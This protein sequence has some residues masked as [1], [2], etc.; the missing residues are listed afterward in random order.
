MPSPCALPCALPCLHAWMLTASEGQP[1]IPNQVTLSGTGGERKLSLELIL[2]IMGHILT[3][4]F[5]FS[6]LTLS[7]PFC[8][9]ILSF[10]V[11]FILLTDVLMQTTSKHT[12]W[13]HTVA[14]SCLPNTALRKFGA[15][16]GENTCRPSMDS[17]E[18]ALFAYQDTDL[19]EVS[20][21]H[22]KTL[23]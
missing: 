6:S 8:L 22:N 13:K 5:F 11:A 7:V 17:T 16:D 2:V 9:S 4:T 15:D 20:N 1:I 3:L 10:C 12:N 19:C 21:Q 18:C 14:Y 23:V